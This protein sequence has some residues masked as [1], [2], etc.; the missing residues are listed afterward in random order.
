MD[1]VGILT[2]IGTSR[3]GLAQ[4][5]VLGQTLARI[6]PDVARVVVSAS[7][8]ARTLSRD[9]WQVIVKD[10]PLLR[11]WFESKLHMWRFTPFR[12]TLFL[13][14]D[15]LPLRNDDGLEQAISALTECDSPVSY[16]ATRT[17]R[18][19][20]QGTRIQDL[21]HRGIEKLWTTRGGG[22]YFWR[23]CTEA[24]AI[25][26]LARKIAHEQWP[27][28]LRYRPLLHGDWVTPDEVAM[29]IALEQL[30]PEVKLPRTDVVTNYRTWHDMKEDARFVHFSGS[31]A[32]YRYY[33]L[34]Q[35]SGASWR[36]ACEASWFW[37]SKM[38][39]KTVNSVRDRAERRFLRPGR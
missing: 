16:Y 4:A 26:T 8:A 38:C 18:G 21:K 15:V 6:Y 24:T 5:R 27:E 31:R 20:Y 3:H 11:N 19:D 25:F 34:A 1:N 30:F 12:A 29:A 17:T 35:E 37:L 10:D 23:T 36:S 14:S 22:H 32:P 39:T 13:D 28:V 33:R 2:T 7:E 9:G